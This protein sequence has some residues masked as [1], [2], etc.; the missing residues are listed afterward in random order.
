MK[1]EFQ[2]RSLLISDDAMERVITLASKAATTSLPVLITGESGTG[3]ELIARYIHQLSRSCHGSFV[4]INCAAIPEALIEAELFGYERGSFT[5][6]FAQRHGKFER[7]NGGTILLDEISEM[8][9]HLQAKLLR[10]L[11][12]G[13]VDRIGGSVPVRVDSRVVATSNRDLVAMVRDGLFRADLFFRL[14]VITVRCLALRGRS[15]AILELAEAFVAAWTETHGGET[16]RIDASARDRLIRHSW[17]GNVRELQNVI[18][19]ALLICDG[20]VLRDEHLDLVRIEDLEN[21]PSTLNLAE[22]EQ[23]HIM[24]VL[25]ASG[26]NR[27]QAAEILGISVRTLH[28]KLKQYSCAG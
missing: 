11:Q 17:P 6:A 18:G 5:G 23:S 20:P 13:E 25:K 3:K 14:N 9:L 10:V 15:K 2:G 28:N 22:V 8:P 21:A 12:E 26:G 24:T 4:S 19:R 16:P 1:L 7:A 27:T